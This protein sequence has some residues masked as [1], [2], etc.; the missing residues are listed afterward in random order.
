VKSG[1]ID[2]DSI[3]SELIKESLYTS[4]FLA[5]DLVIINGEKALNSLMLWDISESRI[6]FTG[7]D[8]PD[9]NAFELKKAVDLF[10]LVGTGKH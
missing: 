4:Y 9:F 3:S 8:W 6:Y 10:K 7:K 5:P 1:K 2:P